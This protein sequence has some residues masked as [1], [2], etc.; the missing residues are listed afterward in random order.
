MTEK[1]PKKF[2]WLVSSEK[3]TE[4]MPQVLSNEN[5]PVEKTAEEMPDEVKNFIKTRCKEA[6]K[7]ENLVI[8][9]GAGS[10]MKGGG[11]S[12]KEIW[13]KIFEKNEENQKNSDSEN[14]KKLFLN[15]VLK[16]ISEDVEKT[17]EES[18]VKNNNLEELL[19]RLEIERK[20]M[21]NRGESCEEISDQIK[22]IN[23]K[24][25]D[26]CSEKNTDSK[27]HENF[28]TRILSARKKT[29]P[30]AKIFTL[31]YDTFFEDAASQIKAVV[32]DGFCFNEERIFSSTDFD[33]DI[34][35]RENSRI[36]KEENFYDK[37]FHL[38][39]MHGSVSWKLD[40]KEIK[41]LDKAQIDEPLLIYPN[42]SKFEESYQMPF[43]EM[44]SRFQISLRAT[45]TTLMIIGYSFGD[46]HINRMIEEAV[47]SNLSL[48]VIVVDEMVEEVDCEKTKEE[49]KSQEERVNLKNI[50]IKYAENSARI[51]CFGMTFENFVK[52]LPEI[53]YKDDREKTLK[54]VIE[55]ASK[56]NQNLNKKDVE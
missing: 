55:E 21:K 51:V 53:S 35:Q 52:V 17:K 3:I 16:L 56:T 45:N 19:S 33:L 30:R 1:S 36:H 15:K 5:K 9:T 43:Y 22:K 27:I 18:F 20:A 4:K 6:L 42:A 28:L 40:G 12:V 14:Q 2:Y 26:L 29:S 54:E 49:P 13:E 25:K 46:A 41:K 7:S 50:L 24:I 38:Y 23:A 31:N 32:I 37:V 11:K 10:S 48:K 44:I 47:D 34:V 8:L 39:K